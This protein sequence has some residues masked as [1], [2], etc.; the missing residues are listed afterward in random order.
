MPPH[1]E[2]DGAG[3]LV[4]DSGWLTGDTQAPGVT[5]TPAAP[6]VADRGRRGDG[7]DGER[8]GAPNRRCRR[9]PTRASRQVVA[10]FFTSASTCGS[11]SAFALP[12]TWAAARRGTA[13]ARSSAS[14][15]PFD[16]AKELVLE[17]HVA[18][19][20][21]RGTSP[22][23]LRAISVCSSGEANTT[24]AEAVAVSEASEDSHSRACTWVL[25]AQF[26]TGNGFKADGLGLVLDR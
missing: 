12:S 9:E 3:F 13:P 16:A 15:C 24:K 22:A 5:R 1:A 4:E 25:R 20:R 2:D 19:N 8:R 6:P 17:A 26:R 7:R 14:I 23:R 21:P 10:P 11:D 18:P